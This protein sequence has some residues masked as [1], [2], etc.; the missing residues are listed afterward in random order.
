VSAWK[1]G[2]KLLSAV[3]IIRQQGL[4]IEA[5][6]GGDVGWETRLH[7]VPDAQPLVFLPSPVGPTALISFTKW[8]HPC[9]NLAMEILPRFIHFFQ[10]SKSTT[11]TL[12]NNF[13]KNRYLRFRA[14][15]GSSRN[16]INP[17]IEK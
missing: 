3:R 9:V 11:C 17:Q 8:M 12:R 5:I 4:L 16:K 7:Q 15:A 1:W 13:L 6:S 14:D 10:Q 2:G